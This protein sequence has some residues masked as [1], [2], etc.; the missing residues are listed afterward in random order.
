MNAELKK[1]N[2]GL[3]KENDELK[4]QLMEANN[5]HSKYVELKKKYRSVHESYQISE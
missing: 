2:I 4:K 1:L 5:F 3:K